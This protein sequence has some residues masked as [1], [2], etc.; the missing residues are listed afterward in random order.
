MGG[1]TSAGAIGWKADLT[2]WTQS[3]APINPF[4][5]A[6]G[7][8]YP[9]NPPVF[10]PPREGDPV[11]IRGVAVT[12][13]GTAWFAS[14]EV[15]AWRGPTYGLASWDGRTFLHVD[16]TSLGAI[17]YNILELTTIPDG[18][19][20][21]AFPTSGL[22]VWKPGEPRGHRLTVSNGL[23][24]EQIRRVSLD[25]MHQP[26]LL[27]VPTDGGLAVLRNVP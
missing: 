2:E 20:V 22:L 26:P 11:N 3:W 8:P 10:N 21:L 4:N 6:F 17:E 19:L 18:R 9:G 5:P 13:D 12:P 15:E 7:D 27:M 1:I 23:P 24:G 14:G 25:L 16:P